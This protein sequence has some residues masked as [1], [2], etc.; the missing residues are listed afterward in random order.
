MK[1]KLRN[2]PKKI[3]MSIEDFNVQALKDLSK[4]EGISMSQFVDRLIQ[5]KYKE[6]QKQ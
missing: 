1:S 4:K 6:S 3:T 5:A 2:N